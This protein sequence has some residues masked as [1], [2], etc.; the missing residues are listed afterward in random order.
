M[1]SLLDS[2]LLAI[3][4]SRRFA[5]AMIDAIPADQY[6]HQPFPGANHALWTL[7]HLAAADAFFLERI[8][9]TPDERF[10]RLQ[11]QFFIGS[12]PSGNLAEYPPVEEVR[13]WFDEARANLV[14]HYRS[15][16]EEQLAQPLPEQWQRMAANP[17]A[18]LARI[19]VHESSHAG[20][21]M[22]VR[23]SLGLPPV[24]A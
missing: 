3:E 5:S 24:F 9:G 8:G 18:L 23:K 20:Q 13:R 6:C 4:Y 7:G 19:S 1:A 12:K 14:A 15:L 16:S 11:G 2:Q 10:A 22:V 17:G 21:L